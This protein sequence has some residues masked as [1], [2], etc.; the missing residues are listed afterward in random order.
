MPKTIV[1]L[2]LT[3]ASSAILAYLAYDWWSVVPVESATFV[4]TQSCLACH[5]DQAS[6]WSG[7]HHDLAMARATVDSVLGDFS[8]VT[9]EHH[10]VTSRMF[11]SGDRF[12][13]NTEGSDGKHHDFEVKYVFGVEPLQQYLVEF[14]RDPELPENAVGRLQV[15]RVSWDTE[16][17]HW[18]HL[19]PPDV[20][21][22]LSP[23]DPLHWTNFG[24]NWNHMCADCHD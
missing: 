11:R 18:F 16:R 10:G 22:K 9:L 7:S 24:Q 1:L 3:V 21:E 19:D 15:L 17:Q 8:D 12:M 14:D 13:I 6:A 4:G 20:S 23:D 5:S 2:V